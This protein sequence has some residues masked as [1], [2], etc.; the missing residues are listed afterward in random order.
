[1]ALVW[2]S[3]ERDRHAAAEREQQ[4]KAWGTE[5]KRKLA[6]GDGAFAGMGKPVMVSL[7]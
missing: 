4:I 5:K 7:S 3:V 1:V 6:T 2:Y